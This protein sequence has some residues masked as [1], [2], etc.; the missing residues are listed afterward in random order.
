MP[1]ASLRWR[2]YFSRVFWIFTVEITT[3]FPIIYDYLLVTSKI[4][5]VLSIHAENF[6]LLCH[7]QVKVPIFFH[8]I[9]WIHKIILMLLLELI[10]AFA[11]FTFTVFLSE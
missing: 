6:I 8:T 4:L 5:S 1:I 7:T 2:V 9:N 10:I 3:Q 11:C